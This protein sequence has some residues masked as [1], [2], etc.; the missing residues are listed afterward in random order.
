MKAGKLYKIHNMKQQRRTTN[1]EKHSVTLRYWL[2]TEIRRKHRDLLSDVCL[3]R[4]NVKY[5][6]KLKLEFLPIHHMH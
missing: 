1:S 2:K 4:D 6:Q 3:L 5:I